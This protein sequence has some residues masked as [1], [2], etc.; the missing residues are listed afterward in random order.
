M[1]EEP[2]S[3]AR[4]SG[5]FDKLPLWRSRKEVRGA[6][7]EQITALGVGAGYRLHCRTPG[8]RAVDVDVTSE[9]I[10][11]RGDGREPADL[12][13]GYLVVYGDGYASWSPPGAFESGYTLLREG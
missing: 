13:D 6:R 11:R 7:V 8:G 9:W 5:E 10:E 3:A 12:V 1:S 4:A 2:A